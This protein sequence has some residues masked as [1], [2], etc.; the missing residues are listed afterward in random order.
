[1]PGIVG[2][3]AKMPPKG[4]E[5]QLPRM[6]EAIRHEAFYTTG[7]WASESLGVYVGWVAQKGSF[8]EKMPIGNERGDV[9]LVFSGEEF[10]EPG[11]ARR[12]KERGHDLDISGPSYLVHLYEED[13]SFPAGLNGRFHGLLTDQ[14]RRTAVLFN[15]RYGMHR[16]YYHESKDAFYFAAEAKAILA[17]CPELRR[18]DAR[19]LGEFVACGCVM[20]NRTLFAGIHLLPP[21]SAWIF[22]GGSVDEKGAYFDPREWEAQEALDPEGYYQELR[23]VFA[24]NLP[25]YFS[26]PQR[27]AMSLTG[28]LDTRMIMAWH[29]AQHGS[30]PCY[31]FGGVVRECQDVVVA[32][33]VAHVCG[34]PHQVLRVGQ[35]F[36]SGFQRYAERAIYLSDG[37]GDVSSG[38]DVYLSQKEREIAPIR[39][40]GNYGGEV[41]RRVRAFKP[42][43]FVRGLFDPGM[44]SYVQQGIATYNNLIDVHPVSFAVFRQAPWYHHGV[45]AVEEA[46]IHVRTPYL[47]NDIVQA[48]Y[49]A[50]IS[51]F[52]TSAV[53]LRL[54]ADGNPS[55]LKIPTDR[56]LTEQRK[57]WPG[58]TGYGLLEFL[59]K[60]EY[61][62]DI[63]MPQWL[64][65]VDQFL[66]PLRLERL[67][68]GR[69]KI[70]HFR[71]WYR[72]ALGGYVREVLLDRR[73]LCRPWVEPKRLEAVVKAHLKG[74]RN[75]TA[76]L[77]KLLTLE[78]IYRVF[79]EKHEVRNCQERLGA[80]LATR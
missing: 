65:C 19:G 28:G 26:G 25:R 76:A 7:M 32:R 36:L 18:M 1:M 52:T 30:L 43:E 11:T 48:L 6:V 51:A 10:P 27:V 40:T 9:A 31:T 44:L 56:G 5:Q 46:Q 64:A 71:I 39:M 60:A 2:V 78:L 23:Q 54:I 66:S 24:Q 57:H 63:G 49:R 35:E 34:Q 4:A 13:P 3:I 58:S 69:H 42:V 79:L 74:S 62:Y 70:S 16:I 8:S 53:C 33:K 45:L 15:D 77:H 68:L 59:F 72:D 38:V 21:A 73:S 50:P 55:L 17:V 80:V 67:F 12:L 22:R 29:G 14:S 47:D 75:Y 20:E 41:L 37:C 61:A